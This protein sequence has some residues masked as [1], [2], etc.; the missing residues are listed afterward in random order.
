MIISEMYTSNRRDWET[1][2]DLFDRFDSEF[3]FTLDACANDQNHKC[4]RYFT[5][6]DDALKQEWHGN[7]WCNPP[8]G[9]GIEKWVEKACHEAQTNADL[10]CLLVFARTDTKWFHKYLYQKPNVEIRFLQ[11]RVKFVGGVRMH[12][13]QVCCA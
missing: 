1:P 9:R 3:H 11:G 8:Y 5:E 13:S 6:R 7:V 2:K 12:H 10:V 4:E